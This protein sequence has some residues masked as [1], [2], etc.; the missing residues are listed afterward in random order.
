[1]FDEWTAGVD[2]AC[3][4]N[5]TQALITRNDETKLIIVNF[6]PQVGRERVAKLFIKKWLE[7]FKYCNQQV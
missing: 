3:S 5:L 6:D 2:E 1:M 7:L 4:F